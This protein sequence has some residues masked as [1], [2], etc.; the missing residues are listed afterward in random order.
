MSYRNRP[1][2]SG[3]HYPTPA[4][5]GIFTREIPAGTLVHALEH[6]GVVVYYRPDLCDPACLGRLQRAYNDAPRSRACGVV[7]MVV[8]PRQDMDHAVAA[9]AW[10]CVDEIGSADPQRI[11]VF[12]RA[13]V[14]H[15]P[16]DAL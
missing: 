1:P 16:E 12:Y 9:A 11:G 8:A 14:D 15:G 4:G 7:K 5:Y 10:G 13:H 6:G 2:P 3:D